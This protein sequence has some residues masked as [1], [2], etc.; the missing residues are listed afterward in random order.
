[1]DS[2]DHCYQLLVPAPSSFWKFSMNLPIVCCLCIICVC[3]SVLPFWDGEGLNKHTGDQMVMCTPKVVAT[4]FLSGPQAA[5]SLRL[6]TA[7]PHP[8]PAPSARSVQLWT[9][10]WSST[11]TTAAASCW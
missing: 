8:V 7:S 4:I 2:E 6:K 9:L 3:A 11:C 1:M 10:P 5:W